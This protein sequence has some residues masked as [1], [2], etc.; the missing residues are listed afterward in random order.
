MPP[1]PTDKPSKERI[2]YLTYKDYAEHWDEIA[3]I[4]FKDAVLRGSFDRFAESGKGKR[5]TSQVD[6]EFLTEIESWRE[7]LARNLAL[8][9]PNLTVRDLNFAVQRTIDRIIF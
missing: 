6:A 3:S 7:T 8:R 5:G 9:N 1:K 4:F 2:I